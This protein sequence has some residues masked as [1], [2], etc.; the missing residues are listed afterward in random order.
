VE[1]VRLVDEAGVDSVIRDRIFEDALI[2]G[3]A[4]IAL[5]DRVTMANSSF[6]GDPDSLFIEIQP[7]R[8]VIGVIGLVNT[9][10]NRCRFQNIGIIG[11]PEAIAQMRAE[12]TKGNESMHVA[13][14]GQ[15]PQAQALAVEDEPAAAHPDQPAP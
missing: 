6:E 4:V 9:T 14:Q 11:I 7:E 3:P 1:V 5:L 12:L 2:V 13:R 10:F 15:V 8:G